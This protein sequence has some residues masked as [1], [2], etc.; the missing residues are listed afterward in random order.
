MSSIV[1]SSKNKKQNK[2]A[3][4]IFFLF[5]YQNISCISPEHKSRSDS[6]Y[7]VIYSSSNSQMTEDICVGSRW[8][9]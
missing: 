9:E 6:N 3:G 7:L 2:S 4:F 1:G 8:L 5:L